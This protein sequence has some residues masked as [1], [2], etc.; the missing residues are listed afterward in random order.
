MEYAASQFAVANTTSR[1]LLAPLGSATVPTVPAEV[2][3]GRSIDSLAS[4]RIGGGSLEPGSRGGA[5]GARGGR[6]G[7][8]GDVR[9]MGGRVG[10]AQREPLTSL[11]KFGRRDGN[12]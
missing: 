6:G 11:P 4:N 3:A 12:G 2:P 10:P 1:P 8:G 5:I 7:C 9:E